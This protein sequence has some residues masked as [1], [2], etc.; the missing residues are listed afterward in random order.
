MQTPFD[1]KNKLAARID[2][3]AL[4]AALF[5]LCGGY[6]FFLWRSLPLSLAAGTALFI[7]LLLSLSL[8]ERSTLER[9]DRL[10][11]ERIGGVIALDRLLLLPGSQA[12]QEVCR[13]LACAAGTE[14]ISS[15]LLQHDN[16]TF[17]V[18]MVQ[19]MPGSNASEG[20]VLSAHRARLEAGADRCVLASLGGFTPAATRAA[21]WTDPPIRLLP[22]RQLA[23]LAGRL[24]PATDEEIARHARQ[25]RVPFSWERI[26]A[27]AL[28][29]AKL[30]RHLCCAGLLLL[31]YLFT[32]SLIALICAL[33]SFCLAILCH[34]ENVRTFRL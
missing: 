22:G 15:C 27:L 30:R 25:R 24:H 13:I 28:A 2:R 14:T 4:R 34:R 1:T 18:R 31:F 8:F 10:L 29:P 12:A 32:K 33:L 16:E 6:F 19:C 26:R 11:R 20:D 5:L 17:L 23:L 9:R 7:L 3:L 21:E